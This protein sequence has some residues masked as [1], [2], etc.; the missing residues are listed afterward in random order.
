MAMLIEFYIPP[1]FHKLV[2]QVPR[3][4]RC[5]VLEF[6]DKKSARVNKPTL[7]TKGTRQRYAALLPFGF[8][9]A[10]DTGF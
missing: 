8:F 7:V 4:R 2:R 3:T 1:H 10:F 5:K 6:P 9:G